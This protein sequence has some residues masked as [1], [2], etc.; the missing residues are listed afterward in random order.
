[1]RAIEIDPLYINGH[2]TVATTLISYGERLDDA[3]RHLHTALRL[4]PTTQRVRNIIEE[5][6]ASALER[7]L[8]A[9]FIT[10]DQYKEDRWRRPEYQKETAGS[11][12]TATPQAPVKPN[13]PETPAV[14]ERKSAG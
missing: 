7:A 8:K 12:A 1:M 5:D 14:K 11:P 6:I 9:R 13:T 10:E 3:E 4:A 2:R